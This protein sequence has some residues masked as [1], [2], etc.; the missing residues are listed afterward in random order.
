M[1]LRDILLN[2]LH[3]NNLPALRSVRYFS[4]NTHDLYRLI[5]GA[6]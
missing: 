6:S 5:V 3:L 2:L 1:Y 4:A